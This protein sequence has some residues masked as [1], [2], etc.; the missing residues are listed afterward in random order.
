MILVCVTYN[1][2]SEIWTVLS[3]VSQSLESYTGSLIDLHEREQTGFKDNE[4]ADCR[5]NRL[6]DRRPYR[7]VESVKGI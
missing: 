2:P 3:N 5:Y 1:F 4:F 7:T 6:K